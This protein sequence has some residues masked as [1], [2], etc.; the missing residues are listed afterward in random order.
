[1]KQAGNTSLVVNPWR[2]SQRQHILRHL[3]KP[4]TTGTRKALIISPPLFV[5]QVDWVPTA[6]GSSRRF[7]TGNSCNVCHMCS[8]HRQSRKRRRS[9]LHLPQDRDQERSRRHRP[10]TKGSG[11]RR[12]DHLL[13]GPWWV[14]WSTLSSAA[15]PCLDHGECRGSEIL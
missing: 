10:R 15:A 11:V 8:H 7:T 4:A 5:Y 6:A 1:V 13:T 3:Q 9:D 12:R 2:W 14:R